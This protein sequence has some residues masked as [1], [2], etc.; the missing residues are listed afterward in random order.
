MKSLS[1]N[2]LTHLAG[3]T[4]TLATIW[5]ITR[6]DA[7]VFRFTD[8]DQDLSVGGNTYVAAVGYAPSAVK[9]GIDA[10]TDNMETQGILDDLGI[11]AEDLLAGLFNHAEVSLQAVNWATPA[12]GTVDILKGFLGDVSTETG[13]FTAELMSLSQ[14]LRT[15][16]GRLYLPACDADLFDTRCGVNP[17][18]FTATGA[19]T[20]ATSE[21]QFTDTARTESDDHWN[22]GLLTFTSGEND[23]L[24]IDVKTSLATGVMTLYEPMPFDIA[25]SDTY[26]VRTGCD[27]TDT[28]CKDRYSNLNNFRGFPHLVGITEL[29]RGPE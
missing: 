17:A 19:V 25:V 23:G 20:T 27:K 14:K 3:D 24:S 8:H 16:I 1:A 9:H 4:W 6:Q 29:L 18:S 28:M 2:W 12:D 7:T 11:K 22:G 13:M 5:T 26:S 21:I 15:N 10:S